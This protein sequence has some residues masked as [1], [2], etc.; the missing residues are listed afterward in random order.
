MPLVGQHLDLAIV[1][2]PDAF[3]GDAVLGLQ[4]EVDDTAFRGWH[5]LECD[6]VAGG[7]D[8]GGDFVG[9][10]DEGALAAAAVALDVDGEDE[11]TLVL[12]RDE[13]VEQVLECVQ[14]LTATADEDGEFVRGLVAVTEDVEDLGDEADAIARSLRVAGGDAGVAE[15]E[16]DEQVAEGAAEEVDFVLGTVVDGDGQVGWS[17]GD[18]NFV[19]GG[20]GVDGAAVTGLALASVTATA[21]GAPTVA[22]AA[23]AATATG[24][25][26]TRAF[27]A[28]LVARWAV[29]AVA[30]LVSIAA[31]WPV[32][33]VATLVSIASRWAVIAV[34]ALVSIA[35]RW[36]VSAVATG[37]LV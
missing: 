24:A 21:T 1:T 9:H 28:R 18:E 10:V 5:G 14:C 35:S 2:A 12:L 26:A 31:R 15:A 23:V 19:L 3:G 17:A 8:F 34:A 16:E 6:D 22:A 37:L 7:T 11:V 30:A 29:I 27:A 32:S 36:S 13:D 20:D 33:A 25:T 4:G